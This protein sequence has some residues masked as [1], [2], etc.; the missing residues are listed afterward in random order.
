MDA[1]R[2]AGIGLIAV[3]ACTRPALADA[4]AKQQPITRAAPPEVRTARE[5]A[6]PERTPAVMD[7]MRHPFSAEEKQHMRE[8]L[9]RARLE[10]EAARLAIERSLRES[11]A[12]AGAVAAQIKANEPAIRL[13]IGQARSASAF[14]VHR[15]LAA[16]RTEVTRQ[17][18]DPKTLAALQRALDR[19]DAK[20]AERQARAL[21]DMP[22]QA[23]PQED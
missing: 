5:A 8:A 21:P 17:N 12:A 11:R 1:L 2:V 16:A 15:A 4:G 10:I 18:L 9:Q 19:A 23:A 22:D 6:A 20:L 3:L 13:A 7:A 14:Q